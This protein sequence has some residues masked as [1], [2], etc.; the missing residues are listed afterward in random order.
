MGAVSHMCLDQDT[1][2]RRAGRDLRA[3][4]TMPRTRPRVA[5][6]AGVYLALSTAMSPGLQ[7]DPVLG[8]AGVAVVVGLAAP[9]VY[10]GLVRKR[11]S[12]RPR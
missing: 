10:I 12:P 8:C 3:A 4:R 7:V 6:L 11:R 9:G 5:A 2:R 1:G